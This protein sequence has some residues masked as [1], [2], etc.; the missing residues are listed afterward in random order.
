MCCGA[1]LPGQCGA[2][3]GRDRALLLPAVPP[4]APAA[5]HGCLCHPP[6][7]APPRLPPLV[8]AAGA[9]GVLRRCGPARAAAAAAAGACI[10]AAASSML[11]SSSIACAAAASWSN[12]FDRWRRCPA[13]LHVAAGSSGI[14]REG[15]ATSPA[16][17]PAVAQ[18]VRK[19]CCRL[20]RR[21]GV[22]ARHLPSLP[23]PV[24]PAQP[25]ALPAAPP[26][27]R[28]LLVVGALAR[29]TGG[30]A[31]QPGAGARCWLE[32]MTIPSSQL[33]ARRRMANRAC[34]PAHPRSQ[35][36]RELS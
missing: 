26:L 5:P 15:L 19:S 9:V 7:P 1:G 31:G 18:I 36:S 29:A 35:Q 27:L 4:D 33:S 24:P 3:C 17:Q 32:L 30:M 28:F 14:A 20:L 21:V 23:P 6:T 34:L 25:P 10:G 16:P 12:M 11:S 22:A 13:G 2:G 8:P